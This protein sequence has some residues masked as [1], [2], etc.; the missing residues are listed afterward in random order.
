MKKTDIAMI[1]LIASI[2]VIGSFLIT[3]AIVG[4]STTKEKTA[5]DIVR[6]EVEDMTPDTT[7]FNGNAINP[8]VEVQVGAQNQ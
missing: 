2:S 3:N 4:K 8:T 1:I 6:I 5:Q 7:I